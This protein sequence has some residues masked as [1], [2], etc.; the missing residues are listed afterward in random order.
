MNER[1][2]TTPVKKSLFAGSI[3]YDSD[4]EKEGKNRKEKEP[5]FEQPRFVRYVILKI[6]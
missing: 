3:Q 2:F 1:L 4:E 6:F 5:T